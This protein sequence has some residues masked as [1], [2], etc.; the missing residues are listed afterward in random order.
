MI[1]F[2]LFVLFGIVFLE[3]EKGASNESSIFFIFFFPNVMK[4]IYS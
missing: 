3:L 4:K 2:V 1:I